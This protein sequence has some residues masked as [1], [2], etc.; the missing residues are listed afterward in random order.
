MRVDVRSAR[1]AAPDAATTR[2]NFR[3]RPGAGAGSATYTTIKTGAPVLA[4]FALDADGQQR[5]AG[6]IGS[7][8]WSMG[9]YQQDY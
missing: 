5:P 4:P 8:G 9:A 7:L 6:V 3:L 2:G 1:S